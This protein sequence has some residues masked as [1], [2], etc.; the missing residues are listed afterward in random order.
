MSAA[1]IPMSTALFALFATLAGCG[2][3]RPFTELN[4][5]PPGGATDT[6]TFQ[7]DCRDTPH[8]DGATIIEGVGQG[9]FQG[10]TNY[11]A[12]CTYQG[13]PLPWKLLGIFHATVRAGDQGWQRWTDAA[14][15]RAKAMGCPGIA[16]RTFP[17]TAGDSYEA[18]G[19]LCINPGAAD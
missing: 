11:Y 19:A 16:V 9:T 2:G 5:G 17:P 6:R 7:I 12:A 15:T 10:G 8:A 18:I 3:T 13:K 4:G 1:S 14:V